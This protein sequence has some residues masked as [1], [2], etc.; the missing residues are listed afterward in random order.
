MATLK[1]LAKGNSDTVL[2]GDVA[3]IPVRGTALRGNLAHYRL[4]GGFVDIKDVDT[5]PGR[6]EGFCNRPPNSAGAPCHHGDFMSQTR[7]ISS[8]FQMTV[9]FETIYSKPLLNLLGATAR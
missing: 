2:D 7:R 5:S 3:T 1:Y 9:L 4:G 6:G 8:C